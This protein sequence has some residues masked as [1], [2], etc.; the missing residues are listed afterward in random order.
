MT[1]RQLAPAAFVL[2]LALA[3]VSAVV[4]PALLPAFAVLFGVYGAAV[5]G[6]AIRA[7]RGQGLRCA[8]ALMV[9]FPTLHA[10][11]GF[12]FWRGLWRALFPPRAG[13][14]PAAIP[15]SR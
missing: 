2:A 8:L 1:A 10:S 12:G 7:A 4:R 13:I 3:V 11:Y 14:D 15:L 5:A 9:A 6:C